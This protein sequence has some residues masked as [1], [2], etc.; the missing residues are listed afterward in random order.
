MQPWPFPPLNICIDIGGCRGYRAREC[1]GCSA[2]GSRIV[3]AAPQPNVRYC[4]RSLKT[5]C[6]KGHS[7]GRESSELTPHAPGA[8]AAVGDSSRDDPHDSPRP[9]GARGRQSAVRYGTDTT[10]VVC[11]HRVAV[12]P[13]FRLCGLIGFQSATRGAAEA[14]VLG[15]RCRVLTRNA[16]DDEHVKR[17]GS[18]VIWV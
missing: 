15:S 12:E 1:A 2:H 8:R 4:T 3:E 10:A 11:H 17:D 6:P 7:A 16:T 18:I 5:H 14:S 13:T 9:R